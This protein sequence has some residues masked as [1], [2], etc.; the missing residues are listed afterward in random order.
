M[1]SPEEQLHKTVGDI[2]VEIKQE[3]LVTPDDHWVII[4]TESDERWRAVRYLAKLGG[5]KAIEHSPLTS[6]LKIIQEMNGRIYK[7]NAYKVEP[8]QPKFDEIYKQYHPEEEKPIT[9]K[10]PYKKD[11]LFYALWKY[12]NAHRLTGKSLIAFFDLLP[13]EKNDRF[14]IFEFVNALKELGV[15]LENITFHTD[16][17]KK[18]SVSEHEFLNEYFIENPSKNFSK[19]IKKLFNNKATFT[20][21]Y[22]IFGKFDELPKAKLQLSGLLEFIEFSPKPSY[23]NISPLKNEIDRYLQCF[24]DDKLF[25]PELKNFYR[26]SKQKDIFIQNIE[27]YVKD[28]GD[29]FLYKQGKSILNGKIANHGNEEYLFIHTLAAME[30]LGFLEVEGIL[31]MDMDTPPEK[32]KD[33]Y[34]VRMN[35]TQ[36]L[37]DEYKRQTIY[38]PA[39]TDKAKVEAAHKLTN[40]DENESK[41]NVRNKPNKNKLNFFPDTGDVEYHTETAVVTNGHKDFAFLSLLN[42]Y[43]NTPFNVKEIQEHCNPSVNNPAHKF[44]G[45]KDVDDT[46]RQIRAKL[47]IKKGAF[48]PIMKRGEKGNKVWIWV[49]K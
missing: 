44:K 42:D 31:T 36:K 9:E 12:S 47:R 17:Y 4:A 14:T 39:Y 22:N 10:L 18:Y 11:G 2:L 37:L 20:D 49:E 27:R 5:L 35:V 41:G 19:A 45:E 15:E 25:S 24:I 40:P 48:F 1:A 13:L 33:D 16:I 23:K 6:P 29:S 30:K 8:L 34:K 26:F 43:K 46:I 28:Y 38:I 7:P 32:Q 3:V 21:I